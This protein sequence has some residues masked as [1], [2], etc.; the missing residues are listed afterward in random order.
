MT[1]NSYTH[2]LYIYYSEI[3]GGKNCKRKQILES[4][5]SFTTNI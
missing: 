3:K 4:V 2:T 5:I 1:I